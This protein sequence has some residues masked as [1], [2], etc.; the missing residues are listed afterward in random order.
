MKPCWL[1]PT[2]L[3]A[4]TPLPATAAG[5]PPTVVQ[6][7]AD[8]GPPPIPRFYCRVRLALPDG[9]TVYAGRSIDGDGKPIG[10]SA[11]WSNLTGP[12]DSRPLSLH[13]RFTSPEAPLSASGGRLELYIKTGTPM[14][15]PLALAFT[16]P[17][18]RVPLRIDA[19]LGYEKPENATASLPLEQ[20]LG[21]AGDE[22][23]ITVSIIQGQG[24]RARQR[25]QGEA[26][27]A[28]LREVAARVPEVNT[29]IDALAQD[30]PKNCIP[31]Q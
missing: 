20:L 2:A 27:L 19:G 31:A 17:G 22:N 15:Y 14:D 6:V 7:P 28:I 13:A 12:G 9:S 29:P 4:L 3:A 23:R 24:R 26:D 8:E 25:W 18:S 10:T 16:R 1:V 21:W 11:S 5:N 30:P